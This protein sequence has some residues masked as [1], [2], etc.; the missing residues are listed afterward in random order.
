MSPMRDGTGQ[1]VKIGLLSFWSGKRWVSQYDF[2]AKKR[3]L[4]GQIWNLKKK[5][6]DICL[7]ENVSQWKCVKKRDSSR[8]RCYLP[9]SPP[10]HAN[11]LTQNS[12]S[13]HS[14]NSVTI[15]ISIFTIITILISITISIFTI[16]TIST[17]WKSGNLWS[18]NNHH[19]CHYH[20]HHRYHVNCHWLDDL[21]NQVSKND[22]KGELER[23]YWGQ[24][25]STLLKW[26]W[27]SQKLWTWI[28]FGL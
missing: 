9:K 12:H 26:S 19:R 16:I 10:T 21:V 3:K 25:W 11:R 24:F 13:C 2:S 20:N 7:C 22:S 23:L 6:C 28:S 18:L 8:C 5:D 27:S 15:I 17:N 14:T 1:Q 4:V